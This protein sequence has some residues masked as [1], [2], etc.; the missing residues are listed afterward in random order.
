VKTLPG[1]W[2][3]EKLGV[4]DLAL[5]IRNGRRV[6]VARLA[7]A[8]RIVGALRFAEAVLP[9]AAP[10]RTSSAHRPARRIL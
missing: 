9:P 5:I 8:K 2:R 6:G 3:T 4:G 1:R 10:S 7:E